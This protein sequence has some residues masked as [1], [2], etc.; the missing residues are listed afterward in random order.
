[1]VLVV[2]ELVRRGLHVLEYIDM[3][4]QGM[5]VTNTNISHTKSS[6]NT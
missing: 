5:C 3:Y 4:T 1:V 2:D 6:N